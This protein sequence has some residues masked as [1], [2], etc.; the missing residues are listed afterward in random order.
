MC[1]P[2]FVAN[3]AASHLR[4]C[5]WL[6]GI[7]ANSVPDLIRIGRYPYAFADK[8]ESNSYLLLFLTPAPG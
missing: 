6:P 1:C 4:R 7:I 8:L 2:G 3:S 5:T